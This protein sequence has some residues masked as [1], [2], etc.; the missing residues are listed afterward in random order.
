MWQLATG[1]LRIII[2]NKWHKMASCETSCNRTILCLVFG[3]PPRLRRPLCGESP[4]HRRRP[5]PHSSPRSMPSHK[6]PSCA[7]SSR[8]LVR[9]D[10]VES[11]LRDRVTKSRQKLL[12]QAAPSELIDF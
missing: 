3:T 4:T 5:E 12:L 1:G 8:R 9:G 11:F 2:S 6:M 10:Y 7:T